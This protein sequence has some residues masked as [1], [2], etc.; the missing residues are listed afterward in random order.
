MSGS[1]R[2]ME[3][4]NALNYVDDHL[5]ELDSASYQLINNELKR[6]YD[7][8]RELEQRVSPSTQRRLRSPRRLFTQKN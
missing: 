5:E 4:I 7:R 1:N 6:I 8:S 2:L 3:M